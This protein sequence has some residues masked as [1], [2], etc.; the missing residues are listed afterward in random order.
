MNKIFFLFHRFKKINN[1]TFSSLFAPLLILIILCMLILPLPSFVLDLFFTLNIAISIIILIVAMF[2]TRTLD[3]SS[4]P[5]VLL[6]STLLRLSLNIAST[7]IILLNGHLGSFSAG[8]VIE[9]FGFFLISG[10]FFIGIVIFIIL[11]IINFLVITKGSGRIAE[12]GARFILDAMPGKQMAI[13][14]DLNAGIISEQEAKIRRLNV[15]READ[16]YGS[17]DGASKFI[18]GDAIAGIVIMVVNIIGG[19]IV[20]I[21]QHNMVFLQAAKIYSILT[22]GDGLVAQIPSLIISIASGVILTHVSSEKISISEQMISQIFNNPQVIFFSGVIFFIFSLIPGMPNFIFLFFT[23]NLFILS[24]YLYNKQCTKRTFDKKS[25]F[26]EKKI[27]NLTWNDIQFESLTTLEL[28]SIFL[29]SIYKD[30]YDN[31]LKNLYKLRKN[32]AQDFGFLL[33]DIH[34]IHNHKLEKGRYKILIKGV[35]ISSGD[36]YLDKLLVINRSNNSIAIPGI[37]VI[38]PVF[39]FPSLWIDSNLKKDILKNKLV[40]VDPITV[41]ITHFDKIIRKHLYELFGFQETQ[42]LLDRVSQNY[43]KLVDYLI[44]NI[45]SVTVLQGVL[46][47]L[48]K[49]DISIKDIR[50]ILETLI[51]NGSILKND[52]E[53][54]TDVTRIALRNFITQ[55]FFLK[56]KYIN[57]IGLSSNITDILL[58]CIDDKNHVLEPVFS[59]KLIKKTQLS[60][61]LQKKDNLPIVLLVLPQLRILLSKLFCINIP[62]LT[63]LSFSEISEDRIIKFIYIVGK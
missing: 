6:F 15:H 41:I 55:K 45:I 36:I 57:A 44:P 63:V 58:K 9:S 26:K 10:N 54:L 18:R 12:V 37:K 48:L 2:T 5:S 34:L 28:S 8:H 14:A 31:L 1:Y 59:E 53:K 16:F 21:F 17:M 39:N 23:I 49:D 60:V 4:F 35:E 62:E 51:E 29:K 47:N 56:N 11:V 50:T 33:P 46:Q 13:D 20:G 7:R 27:L 38:E 40:I 42:Q 43:P 32:I 30:K 24:W 22:I 3:F 52:I 61:S 19:L 25:I